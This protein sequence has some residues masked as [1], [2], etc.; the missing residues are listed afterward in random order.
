[1]C[2]FSLNLG[3]KIRYTSNLY[4]TKV[5]ESYDRVIRNAASANPRARFMINNKGFSRTVVCT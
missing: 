3:T 4:A 2:D 5:S 1:M